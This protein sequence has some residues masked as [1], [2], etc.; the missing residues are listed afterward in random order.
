M[1]NLEHTPACRGLNAGC[2]GIG[3]ICRRIIVPESCEEKKSYVGDVL[4][5]LM[6]VIAVLAFGL[7]FY[8]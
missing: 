2:P 6:F 4:P 3:C 5:V 7:D 8:F 1:S